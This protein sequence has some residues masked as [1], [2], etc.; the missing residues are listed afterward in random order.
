MV[1]KTAEP[2]FTYYDGTAGNRRF[3]RRWICSDLA[4]DSIDPGT[5]GARDRSHRDQHD[6]H[7]VMTCPTP[8]LWCSRQRPR[9]R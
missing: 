2:V 1:N 8:T 7:K 3:R 5:E 4:V 6:D 9:T